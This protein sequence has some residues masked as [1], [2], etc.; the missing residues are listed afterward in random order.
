MLFRGVH[1]PVALCHS[2]CPKTSQEFLASSSREEV[3]S[4]YPGAT[5]IPKKACVILDYLFEERRT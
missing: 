5:K 3:R 2:Q 1:A 4:S